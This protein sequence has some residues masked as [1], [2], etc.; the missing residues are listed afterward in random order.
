MRL[1]L[2]S[3]ALPLSA[4][5][6]IPPTS[7]L[8]LGDISQDQLNSFARLSQASANFDPN[9][10]PFVFT[11]STTLGPMSK[12]ISSMQFVNNTPYCLREAPQ[13]KAI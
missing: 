13:K 7:R 11:R 3:G 9:Q 4:L 2:V 6:A 8:P 10:R 5:G 1:Y 12:T